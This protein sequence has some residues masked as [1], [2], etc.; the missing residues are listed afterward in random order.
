MRQKVKVIH[1]I[2]SSHQNILHGGHSPPLSGKYI[3]IHTHNLSNTEMHSQQNIKK[4]THKF[5]KL[6]L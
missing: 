6:L 4:Y 1:H 3:L 2:S 5:E